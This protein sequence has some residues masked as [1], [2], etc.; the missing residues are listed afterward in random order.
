METSGQACIDLAR[1]L[2]VC[3][4]K[5]TMHSGQV[6][7]SVNSVSLTVSHK[8]SRQ[9]RELTMYPDLRPALYTIRHTE[10]VVKPWERHDLVNRLAR[11]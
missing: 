4:T 7:S 3:F 11:T 6:D 10:H 9:K 8:I 5:G 2:F 1:F